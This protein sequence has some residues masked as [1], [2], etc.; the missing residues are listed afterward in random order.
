MRSQTT[1]ISGLGGRQDALVVRITF[2]FATFALLPVVG[3]R[4]RT[5]PS[6]AAAVVTAL[7]VA[8]QAMI[9]IDL[10]RRQMAYTDI[11]IDTP[12]GE[13]KLRPPHRRVDQR[14]QV[15][16]WELRI[17]LQKVAELIH[18]LL[19]CDNGC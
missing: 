10:H 9:T 7:E 16:I 4:C 11:H 18:Q 12:R 19:V 6:I 5:G 8:K 1:V 17:V 15:A 13:D 3:P 2:R 14:A